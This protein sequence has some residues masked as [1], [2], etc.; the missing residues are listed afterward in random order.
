MERK[1]SNNIQSEEDNNINNS[2]KSNYITNKN[3]CGG[4]SVDSIFSSNSSGE[5]NKN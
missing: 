4:G 5:S 1:K 3:K 2:Q